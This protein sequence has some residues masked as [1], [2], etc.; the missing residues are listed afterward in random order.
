MYPVP[1]EAG[2]LIAAIASLMICVADEI[3]VFCCVRLDF[4]DVSMT[5]QWRNG[6]PATGASPNGALDQAAPIQG[7]GRDRPIAA[8]LAAGGRCTSR[9]QE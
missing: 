4:I 8:G 1:Y 9:V 2:G 6:L 3:A 7:S 5:S